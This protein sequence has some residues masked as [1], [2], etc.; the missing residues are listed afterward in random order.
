MCPEMRRTKLPTGIV[1]ELDMGRWVVMVLL[2]KRSERRGSRDKMGSRDTCEI[3]R[4]VE[5]ASGAPPSP[6]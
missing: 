6:D 2:W 3:E 5:E 1:S 4:H